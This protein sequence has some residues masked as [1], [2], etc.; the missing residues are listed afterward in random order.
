MSISRPYPEPATQPGGPSDLTAWPSHSEQREVIMSTQTRTHSAHHMSARDGRVSRREVLTGATTLG[1]ML[2]SRTAPA[3]TRGPVTL[4]LLLWEHWKVVEGLQKGDPTT[5]PKRRLWFY[6][7][8][9][10]F[11]SE[12]KDIKLQYQTANWNVATQTFIAA[13]QAGNPPDVMGA[14]SQD[15]QPLANA[16]YVADLGQ[17]KYNEWD[18][19]NQAVLRE[20]C[21]VDG[22]IVA[23]P[24]YLT[25]TGL[26]YIKPLL[27]QAGIKEPPKTWDDAI[28]VGKALTKDTR[29]TGRPNQWGFGVELSAAS[30]PNPVSFTMPMIRSMGGNIVDKEGRGLMDTPEHRRI[31]KL[32]QDLYHDHKILA[33]ESMTMKANDEVDLFTTKSWAMGIVIHA[34]LPPIIEKMGAD[35]FGFAPYP[36]FPGNEPRSYSEVYG[37]LISSKAAKDPQKGPAAFEL[38]KAIGAVDTLLLAAKY[39]FGAPSRKSALTNAVY[40][41]DPLLGYLAD[42]TFKTAAPFPFIKE[43]GFYAETFIEAMNLIVLQR[44]PVDDTLKRQ[45]AKYEA[46]LR[47]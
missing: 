5:V 36:V 18:D 31:A 34:L 17:F 26:G 44:Q 42:Y 1:L 35:S 39:Q 19:F 10:R 20:A 4:N 40:K 2:A 43:V 3:Q 46:R 6:E 32:L 12:H 33:P 8:I 13:S 30:T 21:S 41:S 38:L 24:V 16:G 9:K 45:Q 11:E 23:M 25:S 47:R 37:F 22:K 28:R 7:T 27:A 14:Q 29:G 15:N